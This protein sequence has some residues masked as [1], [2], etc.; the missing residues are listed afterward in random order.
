[1]KISVLN[2]P[3]ITFAILLSSL[4]DSEPARAGN[5][6]NPTFVAA[7]TVPAGTTPG[8]VTAGDFNADGKL[9]LAV[10]NR[11]SAKVS[12]LLGRGDG[13][14]QAA[15]NYSVGEGPLS[16]VVGDFNSDGKPDLAVADAS[17]NVWVLA[18]N[19]DGTFQAPVSHSVGDPSYSVAVGDLN[20]DGQPDLVVVKRTTAS[21]SILLGGSGGTLVASG[22]YDTG[23]D[24]LSVAVGDFNGDNNPDLA[25]ANSALFGDSPSVSVLLGN[26]D[27]TFRAAVNY[28]AGTSP[29]SVAV[30]D[31]DGDEKT[32]L[33]VANYGSV[34]DGQFTNSS[35]SMLPGNGDGT[36][37]APVNYDAGQGPLF[38][39]ASD[40]NGDARADLAVANGRSANVSVLFGNGTGAFVPAANYGVGLN[41]DSVAVGDFNGDGQPDMA[42]ANDGGVLVLLNTCVSA[43]VNLA[44]ARSNNTSLTVSWPSPSTGLVLESATSLSPPNWQPAAEAPRVNDGRLEISVALAQQQQ[45]YFRLHKP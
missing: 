15:T 14:F 26:G 29:R 9:D 23:T 1:M 6:P 37:R 18:G 31:F 34:V 30:G 11:F 42:V 21:I 39:V 35:V 22:N 20:R 45:R 40:L 38:V 16:V 44:I 2:P 7:G 41:P 43:G 24:P 28:A 10:A 36:F 5:C 25:V 12:L 3:A 27:G 33:V 17:T 4:F 32:D 13:T 19:G 8:S